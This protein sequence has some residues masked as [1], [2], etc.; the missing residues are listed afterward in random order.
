MSLIPY[1]HF[2][3]WFLLA[4]LTAVV[5]LAWWGYNAIE[6]GN[7]D[8]KVKSAFTR[9]ESYGFSK[10]MPD[11]RIAAPNGDVMRIKDL[12]GRYTVM[13]VWATWCRPCIEELPDLQ[14]LQKMMKRRGV[15]VIAVSADFAKDLEKVEKFLEK[16]DLGNFARYHDIN[17]ELQDKLEIRALPVTYILNKRGRIIY[18]IS[19]K[20]KWDSPRVVEFLEIVAR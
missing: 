15:K 10:S 18:K 16:Y 19:G 11:I 4:G 9:F 2:K 12:K 5:S 7:A 13:N 1:E 8:D 20:A 14:R 6:R 17:G 3:I